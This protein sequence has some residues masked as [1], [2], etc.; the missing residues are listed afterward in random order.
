MISRAETEGGGRIAEERLTDNSFFFTRRQRDSN[1][2][3]SVARE[4]TRER[5]RDRDGRE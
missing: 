2:N 5:D 4:E 3:D 1:D